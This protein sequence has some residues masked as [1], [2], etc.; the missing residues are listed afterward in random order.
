MSRALFLEPVGGVSGD[1]FLAA[2]ADLGVDLAPLAILLHGAGLHGFEIHVERGSEHSI[3]GTRVT[4]KTAGSASDGE[5]HGHG[6]PW[7]EILAILG[8]L[9]EAVAGRATAAFTR[10]AEVEARIHGV[11]VEQVH[12][13]EI[14]AVDSIVDIAGGAWALDALGVERCFTTPPPLG[15]GTTRSQ[16]GVIPVPAPATLELLKGFPVL[17]EGHGELTTPT[18]AAILSTW[19][20]FQ[21]PARFSFSRIGY[22]LGH[23][24]WADRPN[25]LRAS[26]GEVLDPRGP[27]RTVALLEAHLDDA[28]PQLLAHLIETL[29]DAG[30]LDAGLTPL[31][32]KKGRPGHRL[33]VVCEVGHRAALTERILRE[34]PTLGVRFTTAERDE[35]VRELVTVETELGPVRVKIASLA[36]EVVNVTPEYEDCAALARR[37]KVPLKHVLSAATA[38]ANQLWAGRRS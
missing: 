17:L 4:V 28:S 34:S 25:I 5:G 10:L 2:A 14:G 35:L 18:G 23:S 3:R 38:A 27:T 24:R 32:M 6:R 8:Q 9:P 21:P 11:P 1:M 30:A 31:L 36:D 29:M 37:K 7:I 16:H 20:S 22:G 26:L 33:T 13:H 15:S 12:F 19:A